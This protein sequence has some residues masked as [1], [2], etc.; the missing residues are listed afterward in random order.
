MRA[1]AVISSVYGTVKAPASK[2]A[3]QRY[4]AGSLLAEGVSEINSSSL[5]DDSIAAIRIA[6]ALGAEITVKGE[7]VRI[8][9]GFNPSAKEIF[10]GESGLSARMFTPIAALHNHEI[11]LNGKGSILKRPLDMVEDPLRKL[12]VKVV[13]R[14]GFLPLSLTGPLRGGEVTADGSVSSQFI[15]GL[16]MAL[17]VVPGDSRIIVKNLVS[18]PYIDLTISIL[19]EFGI[20]IGN[21]DYR[22]FSVRG[23]QK[24]RAGK[25][26]AEGDWSG[27]TFLLVMGA[28]GGSIEVKG[29]LAGSTQADK[30]VLDAI[31]AAGAEVNVVD[32]SVQIRGRELRGFEFNI[33]DC[34]DLAPPLTVLAMACRGR[35]VLEGAER[36]AAKESDRGKALEETMRSIGGKVKNFGSR[37]EIQ[38]GDRLTGGSADSHNDHRIAM[39][40][41]VSALICDSPVIIDGIESIN[42]SYPG[43]IHDFNSTGGKIEIIK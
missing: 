29:L 24:F 4:V 14:N 17:P 38:G 40:L 22:I 9:G 23:G 30:A 2:S 41:A 42:K 25:F 21:E 36:L 18:R 43:F 5:C 26:N 7:V 31:S 8:R 32:D 34:P 39:A 33:T 20:V 35:S 19:K 3:M 15:T 12:G 10:C 6:E 16:L 11:I 1:R 13:S 28:I 37:I 27:A